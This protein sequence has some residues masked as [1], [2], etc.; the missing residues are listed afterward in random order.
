M[1][2]EEARLF[3]SS[4]DTL[5]TDA[6]DA[7]ASKAV[8]VYPSMRYDNN[9]I[10]AKTRINYNGTLYL[11]TVDLWDTE[12]NNPDNAPTLWERIMYYNGVRIIPESI[13]VTS[14][15]GQGEYGFWEKTGEL[16]QSV[17]PNNVYTPEQYPANWILIPEWPENL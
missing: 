12:A 9:L 7:Q 3:V 8:G 14:V 4:L 10:K 16:Y 5:R 13:T 2:R 17:V 6:T 15:F 1:T 11:A